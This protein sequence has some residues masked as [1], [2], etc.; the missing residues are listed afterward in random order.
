M[1][2]G[3]Q[4]QRAAE[5]VVATL[6]LPSDNEDL[7]GPTDFCN[8]VLPGRL[9]MGAYPKRTSLLKDLLVHGGITCFVS[10]VHHRELDRF[11]LC[12]NCSMP[13]RP[14]VVSVPGCSL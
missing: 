8:W 2:K 14:F 10:L 5:P 3:R 7:S 11:V 1:R 4:Q 9:L 13:I 12:C 6:S